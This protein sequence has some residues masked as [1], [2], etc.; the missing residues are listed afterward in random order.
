MGKLCGERAHIMADQLMGKSHASPLADGP[1]TRAMLDVW[2][3]DFDRACI[4]ERRF[5]RGG[6]VG[7]ACVFGAIA[8][9]LA[10]FADPFGGWRGLWV[11][12][13]REVFIVDCVVVGRAFWLWALAVMLM[14][15]TCLMLAVP[16]HE[17]PPRNPYAPLDDQDSMHAMA[18]LAGLLHEPLLIAYLDGVLHQE[19]DL[20]LHDLRLLRD[21]STS[22]LHS[23]WQTMA[24]DLRVLEEDV[25]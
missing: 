6:L 7:A 20:T 18:M 9:V 25:L 10:M 17:S 14:I 2:A 11:C 16:D 23:K 3:A 22:A 12:G 1:C 5:E 8:V 21:A 13:S 15:G 19:R 4:R 24:R